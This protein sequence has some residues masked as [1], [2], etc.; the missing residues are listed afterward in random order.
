MIYKS[1]YLVLECVNPDLKE[2]VLTGIATLL[3]G[4]PVDWSRVT[5]GAASLATA[6]Q[7]ALQLR[8]PLH[9]FLAQGLNIEVRCLPEGR[10]F[11]KI[12]I[13]SGGLVTYLTLVQNARL[14]VNGAV[15][16]HFQV[17]AESILAHLS[18]QFQFKTDNNVPILRGESGPLG[19]FEQLAPLV[20]ELRLILEVPTREDKRAQRASWT[21]HHVCFEIGGRSLQPLQSFFF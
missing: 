4:L 3:S 12:L 11:F 2:E 16:L 14:A 1:T 7:S 20:V 19:L 10:W 13:A 18:L 15:V 8:S 6:A 21:G 9:G 17:W 5:K